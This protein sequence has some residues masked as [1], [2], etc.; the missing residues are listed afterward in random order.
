MTKP[1]A[2]IEREIF[3]I[4]AHAATLSRTLELLR[5]AL[6]NAHKGRDRRL[7]SALDGEIAYTIRQLAAVQARREKIKREL[8]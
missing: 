6:R 3:E 8:Q 7:V 1:S 4:E 5:I 2:A